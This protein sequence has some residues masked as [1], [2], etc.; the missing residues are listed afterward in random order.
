MAE[1]RMTDEEV[2]V[3]YGL[4]NEAARLRRSAQALKT[5]PGVA[6]RLEGSAAAL[7]RH[8]R[9]FESK[10]ATITASALDRHDRETWSHY[11]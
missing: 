3:R 6:D 10:E 4:L 2:A 8:A 5:L 1:Q 9:G 11:L 7:E